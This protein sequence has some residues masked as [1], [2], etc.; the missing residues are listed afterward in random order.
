MTHIVDSMQAMHYILN[1][2]NLRRYLKRQDLL[3]AFV[4]DLVHDYEHP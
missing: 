1:I 3:A 4:A 2:G